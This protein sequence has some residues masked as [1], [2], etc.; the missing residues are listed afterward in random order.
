VTDVPAIEAEGLV[1]TFG[2]TRA[3]AGLDLFL[4]RGSILGMLGPNGA[5]KTTAV[6]VL[7]T[8]LR[9]D[10]GT[11]RVL[12]ADVVAESARVRQRIALTGQYVA[13]DDYLTGRA[14]LV[15]IGKL[16]RLSRRRARLRADELLV[17]FGLGG[18]ATRAVKTYSG[19]M[20][21][22]LDLA[23]SLIGEPEVL[24]LDEPTTGL[25]PRSRAVMWQII[26]ELA[27]GGTTL[28]LTT[29]Y[30]DEAD[31]LADRIVVV[32]AGRAIAEG[33]PDELKAKVGDNRLTLTLAP[34]SDLNAA[35]PAVSR[36]AGGPVEVDAER[37]RLVAPV[38]AADG[39]TTEMI[40]SLDVAGVKVTDVQLSRPSLDDV[41]LVLTGHGAEDRNDPNV[42]D[43]EGGAAA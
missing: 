26:R 11:A 20:R 29:Q 9:P 43:R 34:G 32:D 38:P 22:R 18:A 36:Q 23:A 19:G 37:R 4:P 21:R 5:G 10:A 7:A 28:L 33:T 8:L 40:R 3:L 31:Q 13:L 24:F 2:S 14:N 17:R 15:M 39:I 30:L 1:K 42:A 25:D 6:R 27:T 16:C 41:F 35:L 12:G